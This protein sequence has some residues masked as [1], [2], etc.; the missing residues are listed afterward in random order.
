MIPFSHHGFSHPGESNKII[1]G[2]YVGPKRSSEITNWI[3]S[4]SEPTV[5]SILKE[6]EEL[7]FINKL[8][9]SPRNVQYSLTERGRTLVEKDFAKAENTLVELVRNASK[10]E[11][12]IIEIL[13]D[14]LVKELPREWKKPEKREILKKYV[15][16][17]LEKAKEGVVNAINFAVEVESV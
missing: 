8:E 15:A 12:I 6:L 11:E 9:K 10:Q 16:K 5:Y 17:E 7:G 13:M 1:T 2:L 3:D 4:V 14:D